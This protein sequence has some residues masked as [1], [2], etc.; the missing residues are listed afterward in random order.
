MKMLL[1][2]ICLKETIAELC[3]GKALSAQAL[4]RIFGKHFSSIQIKECLL[5]LLKNDCVSC[6]NNR[7]QVKKLTSVDAFMEKLAANILVGNQLQKSES[8]RQESNSDSPK[9]DELPDK[10]TIKSNKSKKKRAAKSTVTTD[11]KK[12]LSQKEKADVYP[13]KIIP[14]IKDKKMLVQCPQC[15]TSFP[16]IPE[17]MGM[18]VECDHC[19]L[20]FYIVSELPLKIQK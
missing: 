4:S 14:S 17:Y 9:T 5:E 8:C 15:N 10:Q 3:K 18:K 2:E 19:S 6:V 1:D 20:K 7:W 13:E 16:I 11:V 12:T